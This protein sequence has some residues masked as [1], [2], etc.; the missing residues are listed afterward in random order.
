MLICRVFA[1][2]ANQ[3]FRTPNLNSFPYMYYTDFALYKYG[4]I[5]IVVSRG[6]MRICSVYTRYY[7]WLIT[8]HCLG[9]RFCG[10]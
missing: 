2:V 3:F 1:T 4:S 9:V 5:V 6:G 10:G 8:K 7:Y